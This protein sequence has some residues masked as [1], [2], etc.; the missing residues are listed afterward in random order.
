MCL[1]YNGCFE[2]AVAEESKSREKSELTQK[3]YVTR[4]ENIETK[5]KVMKEYL[6]K[7]CENEQFRF[8]KDN[9]MFGILKE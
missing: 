9:D 2:A 6:K 5:K 8:T 4:L 7:Y 1:Q 3:L